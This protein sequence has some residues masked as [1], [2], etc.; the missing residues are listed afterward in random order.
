[1]SARKKR[2]LIINYDFQM[3]LKSFGANIIVGMI[4]IAIAAASITFY[5]V[6]VFQDIAEREEF[7]LQN[8]VP[9]QFYCTVIEMCLSKSNSSLDNYLITKDAKFK[10]K[11]A[12][13]W[14]A[15]FKAARDS[16]LS[17]TKAWNNTDATS[18]VYN[19][20]VKSSRLRDEQDRIE[21][22]FIATPEEKTADKN[23]T[24][25]TLDPFLNDFGG[26]GMDD[27]FGGGDIGGG[28]NIAEETPQT[29]NFNRIAEIKNLNLIEE[30]VL[31]LIDFLIDIQKNQLYVAQR[32]N[33]RDK[34]SIPIVMISLFVAVVAVGFIL[35]TRIIRMINRRLAEFKETYS[36]MAKGT[37]PPT[38]Y[39]VKDETH[40]LIT[41]T[42]L[43]VK[44]LHLVK[45]LAQEVGEGDFETDTVA[46]HGRGDLGNALVDMKKSLKAVSEKDAI[47]N[48]SSE[49][50]K[51]FGDILREN[52]DDLTGLAEGLISHLIKYLKANQG[53]IY[54]QD[55]TTTI[56]QLELRASYAYDRLKTRKQIIEKGEG[57]LGEA[58]QEKRTIHLSE[59]PQ[60]YFRITSGLGEALPEH[61]LIVPLKLNENVNGMIEIASFHKFQPHEIDFVEKL[62][63]STASTLIT[64]ENNE[65]TK[66][67]LETSQ[68]T[69]E[70]LRAQE[71][72]MRQNLEE[73][74]AMQEEITRQK[75]ELSSFVNAIS[76]ST[77]MIEFNPRGTIVN[78]SEKFMETFNYTYDEIVGK[79][80]TFYV[81]DEVIRSGEFKVM[82]ERMR[83]EEFFQKDIERV[84][85][86]GSS[87]WLRAYY[88]PIKDP[89]G[90]LKKITCLCTDITTEVV[91][92]DEME[93]IKLALEQRSEALDKFLNSIGNATI[94]LE[95]D[96][97][98]Q[99][100][101][102]SERFSVVM[103]YD[104]DEILGKPRTYIMPEDAEDYGDFEDVW[105]KLATRDYIFKDDKRLKKD[106]SV[107][108]LRD[109]YI[110]IK[111]EADQMVKV[112]CIC[113]DITEEVHIKERM[114]AIEKGRK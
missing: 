11:R 110:P 85:K 44:N 37:I 47:R 113:T 92:H 78:V 16:L 81:P 90:D 42:N 28:S 29:P 2:R 36:D 31:H 15:E 12:E 14:N 34:K 40:S 38:M 59:I 84:R 65:K 52:T 112:V 93:R 51:Q 76:L 103:Q 39:D 58:F 43:V 60:N 35:S 101:S 88:I 91:Y 21:R 54:I 67:L 114:E 50:L 26:G 95:Y 82:W 71:E 98:G 107:I 22:E 64:I 9:I 74:T 17:Y 24:V 106:G 3:N 49:G 102:V 48:W 30:E 69:T 6:K 57:L 80:H 87:V 33:A 83:N 72:E 108:W 77:I 45:K 99:I 13:I 68:M 8:T 70:M 55:Q 79:P 56:P 41:S 19:I 32:R 100:I 18:L 27:F 1:M 61:L 23:Q 86:D 53:A 25:I 105:E 20:S 111:N 109:F 4:L 7:H 96:Q 46:F 10:E 66:K 63:E 94:M 97:K 62:S 104:E 5:P 89:T 75:F 73:L